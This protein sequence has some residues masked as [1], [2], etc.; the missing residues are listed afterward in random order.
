MSVRRLEG[1]DVKV[2]QVYGDRDGAR[3]QRETSELTEDYSRARCGLKGTL[4]TQRTRNAAS[5]RPLL[6]RA[7]LQMD[8]SSLVRRFVQ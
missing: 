6:H 4:T 7:T 3:E 8:Q 5:G 2:K 1:L